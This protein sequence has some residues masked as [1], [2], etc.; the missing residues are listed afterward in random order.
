M[1]LTRTAIG[2]VSYP[3]MTQE[4]D[5]ICQHALQLI[6]IKN[7]LVWQQQ[8]NEMQKGRID[9]DIEYLNSINIPQFI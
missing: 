1:F 8:L 5:S 4:V 9:D 2:Q 6:K 3:F 7:S